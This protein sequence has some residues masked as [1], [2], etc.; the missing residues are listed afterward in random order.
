[1][2]KIKAFLKNYYPWFFLV[3]VAFIFL[4]PLPYYID[5]P[6]GV[7]NLNGKIKIAGKNIN[8][9]YNLTYVSE[10]KASI[11]LIIYSWF[12]KDYD[13]YKKNEI[14]L[15]NETDK[16]YNLRDRLFLEESLSNAVI[17]AYN[18]A[19][20]KVNVKNQYL[21]VGYI[22]EGSHNDLKVGDA[23]I[24]IDG[25]NVTT[26]EEIN[27]IINIKNVGD[28]I[29]I[30]VTNNKKIYKRKAIITSE[31]GRKIIGFIPIEVYDYET[32]PI[33]DITTARNESGSSGGLMLSLSIY[34]LLSDDDLAKGRKI[35]GTGTI[36]KYGN[37]GE[38][39]G[40]KYKIKGAIK[41]K[42]DVFFVPKENYA[43]AKKV[44]KE[45]NYSL[46][47]VKVK[48]LKEAI[49]YLK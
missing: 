9:S 23:I 13:V 5:A 32:D 36:D 21:Y 3:I 39:S 24:S 6:G 7:T 46:N 29:I 34:D 19:L 49:N 35:A 27:K 33:V 1:M 40:I 42:V 43:E 44:I 48:T 41:D 18:E 10:Y 37:V 8:G 26:K 38:I 15:D 22:I 20:K 31:S 28:Q 47:L 2:K 17:R 25:I 11:P 12:N 30:K 14:L 4:C 16:E 45:N